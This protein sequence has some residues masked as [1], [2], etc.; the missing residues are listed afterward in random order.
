[1]GPENA[2]TGQTLLTAVYSQNW[3]VPDPA[4][5]PSRRGFQGDK[6]RQLNHRSNS[7]QFRRTGWLSTEERAELMSRPPT[8]CHGLSSNTLDRDTLRWRSWTQRSD[9]QLGEEDSHTDLSLYKITQDTFKKLS[10]QVKDVNT[11]MIN[12]F[13]SNGFR[14]HYMGSE[15]TSP[16]IHSSKLASSLRSTRPSYERY[17]LDT[18][19]DITVQSRQANPMARLPRTGSARSQ[20]SLS[21]RPHSTLSYYSTRS[22]T[23]SYEY[24]RLSHEIVSEL[25]ELDTPSPYY[26]IPDGP[27]RTVK[28]ST[29]SDTESEK[30]DAAEKQEDN[31]EDDERYE[32][33][34][35]QYKVQDFII[36]SDLEDDDVDY[37]ESNIEDEDDDEFSELLSVPFCNMDLFYL[38]CLEDDWKDVIEDKPEGDEEVIMDKLIEL[39]RLQW[40]T[41]NWENDK[42]NKLKKSSNSKQKNGMERAQS[43]GPSTRFRSRNCAEDCMQPACA[44]DC[45]S[46]RV[47]SAKG[48]LHCK[49]KTCNG[50]CTEYG[51]HHF[52]RQPRSDSDDEMLRTRPKSCHSCTR[53]STRANT[54]NA[55]NTV[56]GRPKSAYATFSLSELYNVEPK[57]LGSCSRMNGAVQSAQQI[58]ILPSHATSRSSTPTSTKTFSRPSTAKSTTAHR[59]KGRDAVIPGKSYTSQRKNSITKLCD[60]NIVKMNSRP[61]SRRKRRPR[62]AKK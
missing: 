57:S 11:M 6:R 59:P 46:K 15:K 20:S 47:Q 45:P 8:P 13:R 19:N 1:M 53:K 31:N 4:R 12:K 34:K 56:L 18:S 36:P 5:S 22:S 7:A 44:G 58:V 42:Q 55:N 48:C 51:Y 62:T 43:A 2:M 50:S 49:K 37:N 54:I 16:S 17:Q 23:S 28:P 21:Q 52:V 14:K 35:M 32:R 24:D 38:S 3:P 60:V 30:S 41:I 25:G 33:Q 61:K 9:G 40:L 26:D 10:R 39:E 27:F 29:W